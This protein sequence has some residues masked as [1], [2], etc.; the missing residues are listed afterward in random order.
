[1]EWM[2]IAKY[3][4]S[5][6]SLHIAIWLLVGIFISNFSHRFED[7]LGNNLVS[8]LATLILLSYYTKMLRT[9]FTVIGVTYLEYPANNSV[10]NVMLYDANIDQVSQRQTHPTV[11]SSCASLLLSLS[12]LHSI[13]SFGQWLRPYHTSH[14]TRVPDLKL[15]WSPTPLP[16]KENIAIG[17]DCYLDFDLFSL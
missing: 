14:A 4:C 17:L 15:L 1:M 8:V 3:G 11:S 12:S 16:T 7:L 10:V 9:L 13:A 2:L 5:L 6:C